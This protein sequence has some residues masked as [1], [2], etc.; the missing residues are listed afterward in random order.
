MRSDA[1]PP[2]GRF[3]VERDRCPA[4]A[5]A[6]NETDAALLA[7]D[8]APP[9]FAVVPVWETIR[10]ATAGVVP[11]EARPTVVHGEQDMFMHAPLRSGDGARLAARRSSA[12]TR[13][14]RGRRS[15]S[16]PR[17]AT[18]GGELVNEQYV[19]EFYRGVVAEEGG[20]ETAP[21]HR[22]PEGLAETE[23]LAT[24]GYRV[25]DDQTF[26]YAEASG[27]HFEIHL[28]DVAAQ[29]VGLPGIIVH[30]LCVMAFTG[31]AVLEAAG[32]RE[33][34]RASPSASP[35][36]SGP[37]RRSTTRIWRDRDGRVRVRD[38]ERRGR[39]RDLRD[40]RAEVRSTVI[41]V[42]AVVAIDVHTHAEGSAH[43]GVD[44]LA[45]ELRQ[46][47]KAYFGEEGAARRRRTSPRTTASGRWPRSIFT[48]DAESV[49]GQPPVSN[50]EVAEVAAANPD[51]LIPF[52][53]I[54]PAKGTPGRRSRR[55][56]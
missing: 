23:P 12:C 52:A 50:E 53:S 44:G 22:L 6:T 41:D 4:Y 31:R 18:R 26:R 37:A 1:R 46:A 9:V 17:R 11:D 20:G 21:D 49:T 39:G 55:A 36:R 40:G 47:A 48:V 25:D 3:A 16:R 42:D 13:S 7:G 38:V 30:G 51:V 10:D 32:G 27:D 29:A 8:L 43:G 14:R 5:V 33:R 15:S 56:G 24:I 54:D 35:V 45:P 34:S 2:S 19:T 28:D